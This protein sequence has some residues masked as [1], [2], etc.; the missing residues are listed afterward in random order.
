MRRDCSVLAKSLEV[1]RGMFV[2]GGTQSRKWSGDMWVEG[3]TGKKLGDETCWGY[4]CLRIPIQKE[5]V[6]DGTSIIAYNC[7][8]LKSMDWKPLMIGICLWRKEQNIFVWLMILSQT[9]SSSFL[10][11]SFK[12]LLY[13]NSS[14]TLAYNKAKWGS[15]KG[16][17]F[18][19]KEL[20]SIFIAECL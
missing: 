14:P 3:G 6:V 9:G 8:A 19:Y 2:C 16:G 10:T 20:W 13:L 4:C 11:H 18:R 12:I 5:C 15:K 7:K 17:Q 1:P